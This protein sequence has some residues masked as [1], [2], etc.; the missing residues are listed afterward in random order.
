M[1]FN[2]EYAAEAYLTGQKQSAEQR[3][4]AAAQR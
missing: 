3:Q 2:P 1:F 4:P